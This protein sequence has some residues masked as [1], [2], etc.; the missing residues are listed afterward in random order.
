MT[1]LPVLRL[2]LN[3]RPTPQYQ[4]SLIIKPL[5]PLILL[6]PALSVMAE[7]G[8]PDHQQAQQ[9]QTGTWPSNIAASSSASG[10]TKQTPTATV[11]PTIVVTAIR[12]GRDAFELPASVDRID[13]STIASAGP[14]VNLSEALVR[15]PG[16][17]V[18][19]RQNYAQDLQISSRGFGARSTFG[20]RGVRLYTDG[21]PATMPDGQGQAAN[22]DLESAERLEVLRGPFSALYGNASGGVIQLFTENPQPGQNLEAGVSAGSDGLLRET[23]KS[24]GK[25]GDLSHVLSLSNMEI[26]GYREHSA[27]KRQLLN[28]KLGYDLS[29]D[30]SLMLL[31]NALHMPEAQDPLGLT[32][33]DV[34]ANPKAVAQ[35]ALDYN[36]RKSVDQN[37]LGAVFK[38]RMGSGDIQIT[39]YAGTRD[40]RQFQSIPVAPQNN[41]NHGGG[42][43]DLDR[44]YQ[45]MDLRYS[46][47]HSLLNQ[48]L[49]LTAGISLDQME[50]ERKGFQNFQVNNGVTTLGI[51]GALKRNETNTASNVDP[52]I[53]AEWDVDPQWMLSA[54]LRSSHVR[55]KSNDHY[56]INGTT[57]ANSNPDGNPDDSGS[58]Q[59]SDLTPVFGA[60][61]RYS[62]DLNLYAT[63]GQSFETPTLNEVAY[64]NNAVQTAGLN[65]TVQASSGWHYE[66][67]IKARLAEQL[68]VNAAL[69]RADVDDE[70]AVLSNSAG[71]SVYHNVGKTRRQGA[72][73]AIE[74]QPFDNLRLNAALTY[75]DA[76]YRNRFNL[77]SSGDAVAAGNQIP[78]TSKT[79]AFFEAEWA[80]QP[81]LKTAL[82][83]RHSGKIYVDD[84]NSD[85]ADSYTIASLRLVAEHSFGP[86]TLQGLARLDN[87]TDRNYIGSVI[88]NES[89]GRFFEP[90]QGR[91]WLLGLKLNRQF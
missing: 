40:V 86:Y 41:P 9:Q 87:L 29:P 90:A 71:R 59:F 43:I 2:L 85:A 54:G 57:P 55:F 19:N 48:P 52:Y 5:I 14:R 80:I 84:R 21:I 77:G 65:N 35:P 3:L 67:G 24:S 75:L 34:N 22:F 26:D 17:S 69:F 18:L 1:D 4:T 60:L 46:T 37:Q 73:L 62:P 12:S 42:V 27:A 74:S 13:T 16:I 47:E 45:G 79:M 66:A 49:R 76:S 58:R 88:V 64:R 51:L 33:S 15:V 20:V 39:A 89:N 53:Q 36:T 68:R 70:I 25:S 10:L 7:S 81:Y 32:R 11:L 82:E 50:E 72:E 91:N 8:T 83:L 44:N 78:G 61:Y 31:F 28:A 56:M 63:A 30:S 6:C 23:L 38:G